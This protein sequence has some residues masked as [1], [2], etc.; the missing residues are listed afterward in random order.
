LGEWLVVT[1]CGVKEVMDDQSGHQTG[2]KGLGPSVP[3]RTVPLERA[4]PPRCTEE[5][6]KE[7]VVIEESSIPDSDWPFL[8]PLHNLFPTLLHM[9]T[10]KYCHVCGGLNTG[11]G[12]VIGFISNLRVIT[13][14][15]YYTVAVLHNLQSL[16]TNLFSLSALVFMGL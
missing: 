7:R 13:T 1:D 15:N 8:P 5:E 16:H 12:L 9:G 14:I 3:V 4:T 10:E 11:F 2:K 6:V